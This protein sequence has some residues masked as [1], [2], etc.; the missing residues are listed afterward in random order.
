LDLATQQVLPSTLQPL[1]V[2]EK[3]NGIETTR[4]FVIL[5]AG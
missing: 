1:I 4:G 5:C 2:T 3:G